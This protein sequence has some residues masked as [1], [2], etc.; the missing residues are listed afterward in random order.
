MN[1]ASNHRKRILAVDD[2][3]ANLMI[4][5]ELLGEEYQ[6]ESCDCGEDAIQLAPTFRPDV[7]LLDIMMPGIDGYETCRQLRANPQLQSTKIIMVSAKTRIDD[8]LKGY[9]VGAN[10]YISKPFDHDELRAK[11]NVYLQLKSV[12]EVNLA[13]TR[14]IEVLQHSGRTPLT[15]I[16]GN[17]QLLA[18]ETAPPDEMRVVLSESILRCGERLLKLFGKA[19]HWVELVSGTHEMRFDNVS[20]SDLLHEAIEQADQQAVEKEVTIEWN[21]RPA[22]NVSGDASELRFVIE[23]MIE[24]AIRF[25]P[26]QGLVTIQTR[27]DDEFAIVEVLDQGQGF[28]HTALSDAFSPFANPAA[29]LHNEGDGMSLSICSEIARYHKGELAISNHENGGACVQLKLPLSAA[30]ENPAPQLTLDDFADLN[31]ECTL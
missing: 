13:K 1:N 5:D 23:S 10:D 18:M 17:A 30:L 12:E 24:N 25:S 26:Q 16:I 4:L 14:V 8:R 3:P 21:E 6:V 31:V 11:I 20:I 22:T 9:E 15:P 29:V 28:P 2:I 19:E 27:C 7:I